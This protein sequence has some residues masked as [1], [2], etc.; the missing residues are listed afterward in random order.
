MAEEDDMAGEIPLDA[1][2][3]RLCGELHGHSV[4]CLA[5]RPRL[6]RTMAEERW[7]RRLKE[8]YGFVEH[9]LPGGDLTEN[10]WDVGH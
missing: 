6:Y 2:P 5:V 4:S 9:S 3:C 1:I 10:D 7:F 8:K